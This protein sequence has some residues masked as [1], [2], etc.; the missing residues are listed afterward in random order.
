MQRSRSNM[1]VKSEYWID[2]PQT[3][4][5]TYTL[6]SQQD[7]DKEDRVLWVDAN[8]PS[9]SVTRTQALRWVKSLATGLRRLGVE[10]GDV[11]L[12]LCPNHIYIPV[13]FV[14]LLHPI[15]RDRL[16]LEYLL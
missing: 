9:S 15:R 11:V 5:L 16:T 10:H 4:L 6:G 3:D 12:F 13:A 8:S 2:I 1:P 14:S 7:V